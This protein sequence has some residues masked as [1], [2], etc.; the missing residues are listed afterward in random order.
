V[1]GSIV[2][3][4]NFLPEGPLT[5]GV[6]SGA[7]TPDAYLEE[8]IERWVGGRGGRTRGLTA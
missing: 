1:D 8:A 6:T 5:I 7:S 3:T 4:P 2:V